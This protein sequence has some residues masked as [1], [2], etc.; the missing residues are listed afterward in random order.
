MYRYLRAADSFFWNNLTLTSGR[1][2]DPLDVGWEA[3]DVEAV[4]IEGLALLMP[5]QPNT[6]HT[7]ST[8]HAHPKN[9]DCA[10]TN[11]QYVIHEYCM[12][13]IGKILVVRTGTRMK[14]V[15]TPYWVE[16]SNMSLS[17][18]DILRPMDK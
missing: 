15:S 2:G 10:C 13:F 5:I 8:I 7:I 9:T 17:L 12:P 16:T 14:T 18:L 1:F 3:L 4:A 11:L 6:A